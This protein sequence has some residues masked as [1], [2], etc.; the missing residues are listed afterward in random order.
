M[1]DSEFEGDYDR[2]IVTKSPP[3]NVKSRNVR[4]GRMHWLN[5][6]FLRFTGLLDLKM[7]VFMSEVLIL[8]ADSLVVEALCIKI[9]RKPQ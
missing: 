4:T 5:A 2:K 3:A 9:I 7:I 8:F 1:T 6:R